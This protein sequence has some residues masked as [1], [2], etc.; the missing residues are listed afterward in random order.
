MG[1]DGLPQSGTGQTALL[2]GRNAPAIYGR[3]FGPWVPVRLRPVLKQHNVLR[4]AQESGFS[5]AF[6]NAYPRGFQQSPWARR[7]AAPPLAAQAAGLLTRHQEDLARGEAVSSEIVNTTWRERLG[8]RHLP[9][10]TP[11]EAGANLAAIAAGA[12]LTFFAHYAT[13]LVGHTR[14]M[15]PAIEA[16]ERVDAFLGGLIPSLDPRT[17]L[18]VASDHGNIEEVTTGHT[19][20]PILGLL[21][22]DGAPA[23]RR[24]QTRL[25]DVAQRILD[26]LSI[27]S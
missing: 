17:L 1:V 21:V 9:D 20:N 18:V 12:H 25:T 27:E 26:Y 13:D 3:H 19:R 11:R 24:G 16:L 4:R 14:R 23:L 6:A 15:K 2:T 10:I 22:G 5:C 8:L 7:P